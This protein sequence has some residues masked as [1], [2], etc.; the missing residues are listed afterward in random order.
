MAGHLP[1]SWRRTAAAL[2]DGQSS[3]QLR[4]IGS[5]LLAGGDPW[6]EAYASMRGITSGV[7][8]GTLWPDA[9][10]NGLRGISASAGHDDLDT[11][12]QLE[13]ANY[14]PNQLLR[15]TDSM[16]MAH[17]LE[18]RVPLLDEL[19]LE[20]ALRAPVDS[21]DRSGKER[22]AAAA[23]PELIRRAVAPKQTFT[24]PFD[25]W[26]HGPLAPRARDGLARLTDPDV[27]FDRCAVDALWARWK[28]GRTHWRTI[29][30]LAVLGMWI[31]GR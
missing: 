24:L 11:V 20:A 8:F 27:G 6:R 19:V 5:V 23:S 10:N 7:E 9:P 31:D 30:G 12:T 21:A 2:T 29:W 15:D 1:Q 22:L 16:S 26:L 4:R 14:L 17:G 13:L 25:Q 28:D 18:V 3:H